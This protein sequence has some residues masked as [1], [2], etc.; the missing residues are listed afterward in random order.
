MKLIDRKELDI[1]RNKFLNNMLSGVMM[2][3]FRINKINNVYESLEKYEGH[4]FTGNFLKDFNITYRINP[5][6]ME[7]IPREGGGVIIGNHPTGA[8]EGMILIDAIS[9]IRPD[10]KYMT[11]HLLMRIERLRPFF[12]EVDPLKPQSSLNI[13]G[14][15]ESIEHVRNGGLLVIF[16][17]GEVST[18]QKGFTKLRDREWPGSIMRFIRD[19]GRPVIPVFTDCNNSMAFH[20]LGKIHPVMRAAMLP[21]E[22]LN[23]RN[24]KI[25]V[26]IGAPLTPVKLDV[27]RDI[28][29]YSDFLRAN[30][31]LLGESIYEDEGAASTVERED[32]IPPVDKAKMLREVAELKES[33]HIADHKNFSLFFSDSVSMP[34]IM[35]EIGR[36][37]E[38]T[39]RERGGG[40]NN[41]IDTDGY[42]NYYHHL[43]VWDNEK[44]CVAGSARV[45]IGEVIEGKYGR[46]GFYINSIFELPSSKDDLLPETVELGRSFIVKEYE[47]LIGPVKLLWVGLIKILI[48]NKNYR[49]LLSSV[50]MPGNYRPAS[51]Q[52]I[53]DYIR[54]KHYDYDYASGIKPQRPPGNLCR[55]VEAA[56]VDSIP[57]IAMLDKIVTDLEH[58]RR[59]IHIPVKKFLQAGGKA[60]GFT[61]NKGFNNSLDTLMYIDMYNLPEHMVRMMSKWIGEDMASLFTGK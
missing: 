19:A 46:E 39:F 7:N 33:S 36:L 5:R 47:G 60:M 52:L 2:S 42:D 32:I 1:T 6:Q 17:A 9:R 44:E 57:S 56:Y 16:P 12:I 51:K 20:V 21:R 40:T 4:E 45:G 27:F 14:L 54:K 48:D 13:R 50:S 43:F 34:Y 55:N 10:V 29:G 35:T 18:Y 8:V 11:N 3:V 53:M 25:D 26:A 41:A 59:G 31:Y 28:K 24:S 61:V 23:K 15:R 38:I 37:R 49:Y 30:L 22:M 58:G